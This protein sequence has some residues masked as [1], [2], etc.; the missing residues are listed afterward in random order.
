MTVETG[1]LVGVPMLENLMEAPANGKCN[2]KASV[3]KGARLDCRVLLAE[4]GLDNQRLISLILKKAGAEVTLAEDGR[5]AHD[6]ALAAHEAGDPFD[7]VLMDMQMPVMDGYM[8][9][10]N[11]RLANYTGPIVALTANAMAG[12]EDKCRQSGCDGY[13]T[14]PINAAELLSTIVDALE[15]GGGPIHAAPALRMFDE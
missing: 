11:L 10:K 1:S 14:K 13:A 6:K 12:D 7:V 15:H 9:T 4:D 5:I 3:P 2:S 8:A